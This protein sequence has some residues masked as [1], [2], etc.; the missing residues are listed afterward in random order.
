MTS[1]CRGRCGMQLS[2]IFRKSTEDIKVCVCLWGK[3]TFDCVDFSHHVGTV[4]HQDC[5]MTEANSQPPRFHQHHRA[6]A[7]TGQQKKNSFIFRLKWQIHLPPEEPRAALQK[8]RR[9][10]RCLNPTVPFWP[11]TF[12]CAVAFRNTADANHRFVWIVMFR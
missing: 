6:V 5:D 7:V 4:Q 11:E 3:F 2:E 10:G 12:Y 8:G 1:R 9:P